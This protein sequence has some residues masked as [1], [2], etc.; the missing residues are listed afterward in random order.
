M[1]SASVDPINN[2]ECN[3]GS[4][5][6]DTDRRR[7]GPPRP[8]MARRVMDIQDVL[9]W[10][11]KDELPKNRGE[12]GRH[13]PPAYSSPLG[14]MVAMGTSVDNWSREP[15]HPAAMGP[16]H[17]DALLVEAAVERCAAAAAQQ[18]VDNAPDLLPDLGE[19]GIDERQA[20]VRALGMLGGILARCAKVGRPPFWTESTS[21]QPIYGGNSLPTVVRWEPFFSKTITGEDAEHEALVPVKVRAKGEYPFGAYSPLV[22][23]PSPQTIAEERAE[24]LVWWGALEA[25][26][27]E[28]QGKLASIAVLP[29][30]A[31]QRPWLD[32]RELAKPPRL[33]SDVTARVY[34]T[35]VQEA[36]AAH[37]ALGLRRS[38]HGARSPAAR[39]VGA[40]TRRV[41]SASPA[42]RACAVS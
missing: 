35:E 10:A 25:I 8:E 41:R 29:P 37:R 39:R 19:F 5:R 31:A 7:G 14:R 18:S 27:G 22:Y 11:Y 30:G 17:P 32:K 9:V 28:L 33:F 1:S 4:F 23:D 3:V 12:G 40:P 2:F 20:V 16:P 21:P 34:R 15:G 26:A 42:D 38:H 24:Y 36:A 13:G 6:K